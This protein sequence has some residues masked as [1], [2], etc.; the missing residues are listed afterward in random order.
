MGIQ[1]LIRMAEY[2]GFTVNYSKDSMCAEHYS[3]AKLPMKGWI[4][5]KDH[6]IKVI[7]DCDFSIR[8]ALAHEV[9]HAMTLPRDG[10]AN[11]WMREFNRQLFW[12]GQVERK[13]GE[14]IIAY[15]VLAWRWALVSIPDLPI[16]WAQACLRSYTNV[17][18]KQNGQ[19]I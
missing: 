3:G 2:A 8:I 6:T 16:D 12:E 17:I 10:R 13:L 1:E 9:G 5:V 18:R 11:Q 14:T 19:N 4:N 7:G 15:E